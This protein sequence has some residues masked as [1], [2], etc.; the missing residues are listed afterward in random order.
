MADQ[1]TG[2]TVGRFGDG[3]MGWWPNWRK[4]LPAGAKDTRD[5]T[6]EESA[7]MAKAIHNRATFAE[8]ERLRE[9]IR[10]IR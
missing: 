8:L 10:S 3:P 2:F 5:A 9:M 4:S 1:T 7:L 6:S